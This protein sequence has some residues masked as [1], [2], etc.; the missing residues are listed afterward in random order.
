MARMG[1]VLSWRALN[2]A[3]LARQLLLERTSLSI[4]ATL[5]QVAGIQ[6]QYAPSGYIGLWGRMVGFRRD[7]LTTA[8]ERREVVQGTTLRGTIHLVTPE[9]FQRSNDAVREE[10]TEWWFRATRRTD[11]G[12][13]KQVAGQI[14][15]V[16][17]KGPM[18]RADMIKQLGIDVAT[19]N[20][21]TN[22]LDLIRVPPSGTWENRR[23]DLYALHSAPSRSA[24]EARQEMVARYL[25]A[26]GPASANDTAT[27]LGLKPA[28]VKPLLESHLQLRGPDG[29]DL[30]DIE[31]G[32]LPD[33]ET[34]APPRFLP[35]WDASLL[36]HARRTQILPE[37]YRP[38]IFN[39]K[40]PH[41][42]NTFLIDGQV[43]G[44]WKFKDG[45][46]A[47]TVFERLDRRAA[48]EL[49]QERERLRAFHK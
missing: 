17:R 14:D 39:T 25:R 40:T 32:L 24:S 48:H 6:N 9:L 34:P 15:A 35:V 26:F 10:R 38:L 23:A 12:R 27:F 28:Q 1:D 5:D 33:P 16:L 49:D 18:K 19:W 37:R 8:L 2:R 4:P 43:A 45:D 42:H 31:D 46:I 21:A 13:M 22:Y 20:G 47:T 36:V 29:K 44:T 11:Q 7:H 41:S 3:L 30:F